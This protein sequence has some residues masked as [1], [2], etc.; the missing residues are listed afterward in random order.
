ME[1]LKEIESCS[2]CHRKLDAPRLSLKYIIT[3]AL[4]QVFNLERGLFFTLWSLIKRPEQVIEAFISG[5]RFR[6][7][8]PFR[9]LFTVATGAV[10]MASLADYDIGNYMKLTGDDKALLANV[11]NIVNEYLNI[12]LLLNAPIF[13]LGSWIV[14]RSLKWNYAEHLVLA[15]YG[16]SL[17]VALDIVMDILILPL[18]QI[19]ADFWHTIAQVEIILIAYVFIRVTKKHWFKGFLLFVLSLIV[20]YAF[21]S[22]PTAIGLGIHAYFF[23]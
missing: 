8:N 17:M 9:L 18:P 5:N 20:S 22:I 3:D 15:A 21:I 19:A 1:K 23:S 11:T 13:A 7:M 14:F 12:I 2:H 16:Y 6:Y 4:S 10:I